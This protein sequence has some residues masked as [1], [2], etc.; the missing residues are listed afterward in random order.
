M[1]GKILAGVACERV[2]RHQG[3]ERSDGRALRTGAS[4]LLRPRP[5]AR[6]AAPMADTLSESVLTGKALL[7]LIVT[8]FLCVVKLVSA[9]GLQRLETPGE[10]P[11][12]GARPFPGTAAG[13]SEARRQ[14]AS[15]PAPTTCEN[16]PV[17]DAMTPIF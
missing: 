11:P 6:I 8:I 17:K 10:N 2:F 1:I 7:A 12:R 9:A 5:V 3:L 15:M 14:I 4:V 16:A 13:S